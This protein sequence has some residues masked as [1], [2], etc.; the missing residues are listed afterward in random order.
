M[1]CM[2]NDP[3]ASGIRRHLPPLGATGMGLRRHFFIQARDQ[4]RREAVH[5]FC[6]RGKEHGAREIS[7]LVTLGFWI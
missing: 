2:S 4:F 1:K 6:L 7:Y 3:M 5:S